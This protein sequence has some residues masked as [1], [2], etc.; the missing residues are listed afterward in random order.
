MKKKQ[1][2]RLSEETLST[3]FEQILLT[4]DYIHKRDITLG[5]ITLENILIKNIF[6]ETQDVEVIIRDL[7]QVQSDTLTLLKEKNTKF[8][9]PT[10][11][12]H[13]LQG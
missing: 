2:L 12:N 8:L 9:S 13:K 4:L 5:K 11:L 6:H 7:S 3:I 1:G 10:N